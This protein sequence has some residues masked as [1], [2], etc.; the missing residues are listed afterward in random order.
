MGKK[1]VKKFL[2]FCLLAFLKESYLL[3]RNLLGLIEHPYK[4]IFR[5]ARARDFSQ[6]VLLLAIF[7]ASWLVFCLCLV[8][9]LILGV[10]FGGKIFLGLW[11]GGLVL[12]TLYL[13]YWVW[14]F[15]KLETRSTKEGVSEPLAA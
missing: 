12:A 7:G 13:G 11:G 8:G 10:G 14:V 1:R 6:A 5:I 9:L 4:T 15:I 3:G 2:R